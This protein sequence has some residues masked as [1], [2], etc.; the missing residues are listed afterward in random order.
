MTQILIPEIRTLL[1]QK[2]FLDQQPYTTSSMNMLRM[3]LTNT[4]AYVF[5]VL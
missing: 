5:R 2:K 3:Y 1:S 4:L